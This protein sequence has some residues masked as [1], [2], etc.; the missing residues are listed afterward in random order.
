MFNLCKFCT[1]W[2]LWWRGSTCLVNEKRLC[3][4]L[5]LPIPTSASCSDS[6]TLA[7]RKSEF[8]T[9][10]VSSCDYHLGIAIHDTIFPCTPTLF[11]HESWRG[12]IFCL[13]FYH[14]SSFFHKQ[15]IHLGTFIYI[16]LIFQLALTARNFL[17]DWH[18]SPEEEPFT[19]PAGENYNS[20]KQHKKKCPP[21]WQVGG[22]SGEFRIVSGCTPKGQNVH[23]VC[24]LVC[25]HATTYKW[26]PTRQ[27]NRAV[28][29]LH[30]LQRVIEALLQ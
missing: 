16:L 14:D 1:G 15:R 3:Y 7:I 9:K 6:E 17:Q 22:T 2:T 11:A 30:P 23:P 12:Y 20:S 13:C 4:S 19:P 26:H 18:F 25:T 27:K 5:Y 8:S 24:I 28:R 10:P 29:E 21:R